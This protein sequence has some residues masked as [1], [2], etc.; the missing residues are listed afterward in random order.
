MRM[1]R[2]WYDEGED[3]D[4]RFT[5]ANERTFLAWLRTGLAL[6]GGAIVLAQLV[7]PFTIAGLRTGLAALLALSGTLLSAFSY[8]R[9]ARVQWAMRTQKPLPATRLPFVIGWVA[10]AAGLVVLL[11]V[12][13]RPL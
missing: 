9:W 1:P 13:I 3:P 7:P 8:R 12:L 2:R 4:Y 11:V 5:L 6:V 10:A